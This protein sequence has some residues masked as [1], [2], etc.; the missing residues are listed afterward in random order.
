[1]LH[2]ICG[3]PCAGKSTYV[4]QNA[5]KNDLIIDADKIAAAFGGSKHGASGAPFKVAL[6]AREMAIDYAIKN[7]T[8]AWLV[9]TLP[10]DNRINQYA[11]ADAEIILI[12]TPIDVCMDRAK[13]RPEFTREAVADWHNNAGS[14]KNNALVRRVTME[15]VNQEKTTDSTEKTFTQAELDAIVSDRL[16][17]DR[18]KYADYEAL[19]EKAAKLDE[20]EEQN[21]TDLQKAVERGDTLQAE[22]DKLK[23]ENTVRDLRMSVSEETGVPYSLLTATTEEDIKEQAQAI[24]EYAKPQGYPTVRD[25]GEVKTTGKRSTRD[26]F[27]DWFNQL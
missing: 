7:K 1:M 3:S 12:D 6:N 22:L 19:K 23:T 25:G 18:A 14:L 16:K 9:D 5:T 10:T 15:T 2:V 27:A 20:I 8:D 13:E 21:K 4:E 17:R 11:A 24:L 26:S